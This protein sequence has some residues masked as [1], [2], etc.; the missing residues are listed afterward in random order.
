MTI[1]AINSKTVTFT[2]S[3]EYNHYGAASSTI[4]KEYGTLD[5]RARV[6]HLTRNIKFVA[7][8]DSGWG[9]TLVQYGFMDTDT[10]VI[11][12]GN[13]ILKGVEFVNGG[14]YDT[15]EA[16]LMIKDIRINTTSTLITDSTFHNCQDFCMNIDNAYDVEITNNVFYNAKKFH[17]QTIDMFKFKFSNNLMIGALKRT[18]T[19]FQDF[20]ACFQSYKFFDSKT[21]LVSVFDNVC[22]GSEGHGFA[23]PTVPC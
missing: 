18:T 11:K 6:G 8:A 4:E 5:T 12:T 19:V 22:Q 23:I 16:A 9:Y 15:E 2:P 1:T 17:V 14:Q 20:I 3:L 21:A 7:G 13:L 10:D